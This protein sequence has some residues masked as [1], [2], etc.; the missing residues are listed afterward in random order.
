MHFTGLPACIG[1]RTAFALA[2]ALA[3][4]AS[5][6]RSSL[7]VDESLPDGATA[8]GGV[9][10]ACATCAERNAT[11]GAFDDGCGKRLACGSCGAP[12][13]CGGGGTASQCGCRATATC[14]SAGAE[15]GEILDGCNG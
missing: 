15:C 5:C 4:A 2:L 1:R 6:G 8:E 3:A 9:A 14:A 12:Q 7:L 13:T 11:C 10:P